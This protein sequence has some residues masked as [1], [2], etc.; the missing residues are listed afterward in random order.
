MTDPT[1]D[2]N[3][4]GRIR[5][6][7]GAAL[8][9]GLIGATLAG[10]ASSSN[11]NNSPGSFK[12]QT[13][14]LAVDPLA[15]NSAGFAKFYNDLA[16]VFHQQTGATLKIEN[17]ET[18]ESVTTEMI[19]RAAVSS[20]GPDMIYMGATVF[21]T[22]YY[23]N[24]FASLTAAD[25]R[26]IGGT[27]QFYTSELGL[28]GPDKN[29]LVGI[30][31]YN[32]PDAMAYNTKLFKQAGIAHPPA[33]WNEFIA[34]A[35]KIND[36][37]KGIYG[38]GMDP[39]D[40]TDPWKTLWFMTRQLGGNYVSQD[41]KT[42][43][44]NSEAVQ[45]AMS[46]WFDWYAKFHIVDPHSLTWQASNMEAAFADGKIGELI[47]QKATDVPLYTA[48]AIGDNF[49]FAPTPSI[50]YGMRSLPPGGTAPGTFLSADG[51]AI[52]KYAPLPLALQFLK[53][54]LSTKMQVLQY[55][56]TGSLPVTI[57]AGK[58][59]E[60]MNPKI[61]G[62]FIDSLQTQQGTSFVAAW[63]T[64]EAAMASVTKSLAA[65]IAARGQLP[66]AD[67]NSALNGANS[68]V[69]QQLP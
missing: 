33:T 57:A 10:C 34:D 12:G 32:V 68:S 61:N 31:L 5:R 36:P 60:A 17:T 18:S 19:D 59:V 9:A 48:G 11:N 4:T 27:G 45:T 21:P 26:E 66:G 13:L 7:V 37:S 58:I 44:L 23:S 6:A 25:W 46:F 38:T 50:P 14:S 22:A 64:V 16:N 53:L 63:G 29:D 2:R 54:Y 55:K 1:G 40:S 52:A 51:V 41:N 39:A 67:V 35:Q 15:S 20:S 56:L 49:A 43:T 3:G 47:V 24:A 62:P 8:A 65:E 42:A 30:P 28:S 69:Q